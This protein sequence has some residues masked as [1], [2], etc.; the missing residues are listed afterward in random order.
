[1]KRK[2]QE[3]EKVKI[4]KT[5]LYKSNQLLKGG[6]NQDVN[7]SD[8]PDLKRFGLISELNTKSKEDY[9]K[10]VILPKEGYEMKG[11]IE[12]TGKKPFTAP[13]VENKVENNDTE[14]SEEIRKVDNHFVLPNGKIYKTRK[15]AK[16]ALARLKK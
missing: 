10:K 11:V 8:I 6:T 3:K 14:E 16:R 7:K 2:E 1:M 5:F 12:L 13:F 4:E 15:Q 9:N